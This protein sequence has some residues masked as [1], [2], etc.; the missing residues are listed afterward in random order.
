M[1]AK[2]AVV[3]TQG[4]ISTVDYLYRYE[5]AETLKQRVALQNHEYYRTPSLDM[6]ET[7]SVIRDKM[8]L[9]MMTK[10]S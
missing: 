9:M 4:S 5:W 3:L 6:K 7:S 8:M 2:M 1:A 10:R